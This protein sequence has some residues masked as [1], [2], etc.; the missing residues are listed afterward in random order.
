MQDRQIGGDGERPKWWHVPRPDPLLLMFLVISW[1]LIFAS[2]TLALQRTPQEWLP[3]DLAPDVVADYRLSITQVPK[4]APVRPQIIEAVKRDAQ[5]SR[6]VTPPTA[7]AELASTIQPDLLV[8]PTRSIT[9]TPTPTATPTLALGV[10]GLTLSAGGPYDGDEGKSIPL[11]ARSVSAAPGAVTYRWDLDDDGVYNDAQGASTSVTFYDD[12]DYRVGV[13]ATNQAGVKTSAVASIHVRN[14]APRIQLD[15]DKRVNEGDRVSFA[16]SVTDPGHDGLT[17]V[18][19]FG[20]GTTAEDTLHPKHTYVDD[21][22]YRVRLSAQDDD[23]AV[24]EASLVVRV[25]NLPPAVEAG[26]DQVVDEGGTLTFS[27]QASDPGLRDTL[28]YIWDFDYD[29]ADFNADASGPTVSWTF[30][31][32]PA[33]VV[34]ALLVEDKDRAQSIDRLKVTVNN[35]APTITS[36]S[37]DGPVGEG[38]P[39]TLSVTA[40]DPGNDP[41]FYD[42]DW[43]GEGNFDAQDQ[44]A[45]VSHTW[46]NQGDYSVGIRVRDKDAGQDLA[47]ADVSVYNVPPVARINP[48]ASTLEG[49]AVTW[50][51]SGSNDPGNQ[52]Q[53]SYQWDFGDG[54]PVSTEATASHTYVDN[55][56]YTAT[57]TVTD[58]S[59]ATTTASAAV[60]IL[61]ANPSADA[62]PDQ[63][64]DEGESIGFVGTA[65]DPGTAD[66]LSYAWDF[67]LRED[68]FHT[69]ARG[70][71]PDQDFPDGPANYVVALRVRDDDYPYPTDGGGQSGEALDT[72]NVTVRNVPPKAMAGGPYTGVRGRPVTL[73]GSGQ[74]VA[75]DQPSLGYA[76]AVDGSDQYELA[77]QTVITTWDKIGV[78]SVTL[79]VTDKDGGMG[80]DTARV[81]IVS[82]LPTA[83][84]RGPYEGNEGS[85][86][87][88]EGY[89]T[90]P[91]GDPLTF[92]WDL[93]GV[94]GFETPGRVVTHTWRDNGVY[95]VTLQ[96]DDQLD[97]VATDVATVTVRN[98]A[99]TANA[100]PDQ[101]VSL[102]QTVNFNGAASDPGAD[103]LTYEWDFDYDGSNFTADTVGQNVSHT[104]PSTPADYVVALR[105]TDD[106]GDWGLDTAQVSVQD[107]LPTV[108]AGGPYAGN[109]GSSI[110]LTG[111]GSDPGGG[112]LSFAWDLDGVPG[113]ETP[114]RVVSRAWPDNGDFTVVLQVDNG[115]GGTATDSAI[116]SVSNV[117]PT[118]NAGPDQV[119]SLGQTVNFNGAAS[120][121]GADTLTYEWDFDYDGSNFTAD[122]VGQ[123]VSHTYP[124]T[125][126]GYVVALR[127]TDDDGDWGLDT[128]QVSVQDVLPTA[129]AGGPYAGNEGSSITLTG[130]G[131]DPGGGQLSFAWDLDG[132]PGFEEP[133]QQ[134]SHAWP[135]NG[136]FTVVLQVDNGRGGT[137]TDSA[138]VGVSNVAPTVDAGGPYTTQV[139]VPVTLRATASDV[140]ADP[141][142]FAWDLNND[143]AFDDATG[144]E[145][146]YSWS[147]TR[148][149]TVAVEV[150]DGDGGVASDKATVHVNSLLL[151][152]WLAGPYLLAWGKGRL[153]GRRRPG[154]K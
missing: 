120:D 141:L 124:S 89:G 82:G 78:H 134:V 72:L 42:F 55:G 150:R 30:P 7:L 109:E 95:T 28:T 56:V 21:G 35:V 126:A 11:L 122:A 68:G 36:V 25:S 76:W 132:V 38:S 99:P 10:A 73:S 51:G 138:A 16:A 114:G 17:Y 79:R 70:A 137:A 29:G 46:Y 39:L 143:G 130:T 96:V 139:D 102:G 40:T 8:G 101:V 90:D 123:N 91:S 117:A 65:S 152:A 153:G 12:G 1:S 54:S 34:V 86:I 2:A 9:L 67:D 108:D 4:L 121:P 145:V 50:D 49:S 75:A 85:P 24:S 3:V 92:A 133:G 100:G 61:N 5:V 135:D 98:V 14:V 81:N 43:T 103:T 106:D 33:S 107:V 44:S 97:G 148:T 151:V 45:S 63:T 15:G 22:P 83:D 19:D 94:P 23:G 128:A 113:F 60:T 104:Y 119:V 52:D 37:N 136:D 32:G 48:P 110:T 13:Q 20:D 69:D 112:Q 149:Y 71:T 41:L 53:L 147:A 62:G 74:D 105:V 58:D 59:T 116:V 131:S 31:D 125:P 77:G 87:R 27:G 144:P 88:L 26:P 18:W 64:I 154:S 140:A 118:A 6:M 66:E 127:V 115:R 129:D 57:L 111:T 93:D 146:T 84:A 80:F 142:S 47:M